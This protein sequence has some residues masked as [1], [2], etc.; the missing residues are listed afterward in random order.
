[1]R[2]TGTKR[3]GST[4]ILC[5]FFLWPWFA[6]AQN[7]RAE[8]DE[9]PSFADTEIETAP[10]ILKEAE[11][12]V[13]IE[14]AVYRWGESD[15]ASQNFTLSIR[16]QPDFIDNVK[17][18]SASVR[19]KPN[20]WEKLVRLNLSTRK[21]DTDQ[22]ILNSEIVMTVTGND[23]LL[24]PNQRTF[25]LP[26]TYT[27]PSKSDRSIFV[28]TVKEDFT[29][30]TGAVGLYET[31]LECHTDKVTLYT[32]DPFWIFFEGFPADER[33]FYKLIGPD[34]KEIET[35]P[36]SPGEDFGSGVLASLDGA[37]SPMFKAFNEFESDNWAAIPWKAG[38]YTVLAS[39]P[40]TQYSEV[41]GEY[42]I[43]GDFKEIGTFALV[44]PVLH[45]SGAMRVPTAGR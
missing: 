13:V 33:F 3:N 10:L 30:S 29:G 41:L 1:M 8:E 28:T 40:E 43:A 42:K 37:I 27:P 20:E 22:K 26:I 38:T 14:I 17:L 19:F 9:S 24:S 5:L 31:H 15:D 6:L 12:E 4:G 45:Y 2:P 18:E 34:G 23:P 7:E 36:Y 25:I 16:S 11:E 39:Y 32:V 21:I 44:D 35:M